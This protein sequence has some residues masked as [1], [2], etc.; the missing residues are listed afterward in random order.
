MRYLQKNM[1]K[2]HPGDFYL[3][4]LNI[5]V[6]TYKRICFVFWVLLFSLSEFP[7]QASQGTLQ[8]TGSV[9]NTTCNIYLE[10]E[11]AV[12]GVVNLGRAGINAPSGDGVYFS[13]KP[14]LT[15]PGCSG[16]SAQNRIIMVWTGNFSH[17]LGFLAAQSGEASDAAVFILQDQRPYSSYIMR[18]SLS[19]FVDGETFLREGFIYYSSLLA[20]KLAGTFQAA[21][22]YTVIYN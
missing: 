18:G 7:A 19:A 13:L 4:I 5:N 10:S 20:G 16:L 8:F 22:A 3:M 14:D 1:W 11:G 21:A 6:T 12:S 9:S 2:C 17:P 15:S